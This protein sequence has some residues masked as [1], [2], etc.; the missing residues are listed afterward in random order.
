MVDVGAAIVIST[1][2]EIDAQEIW[3]AM[4]NVDRALG[5]EV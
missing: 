5:F 3:R 1:W 2:F 4:P